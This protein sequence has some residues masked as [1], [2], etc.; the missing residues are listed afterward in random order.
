[1]QT[2]SGSPAVDAATLERW[3]HAHLWH[4]FTQ[5]D[6]WEADGAPLVVEA[7]QGV[8]LI[9]VHGR[10]YLDG[11]SSLWTNV[12]GHRQPRIDA[13][14]V[15]QLGR[16]AH[17]TLLGLSSRPAVELAHRLAR[18]TERQLPGTGLGRVFYSDSGSTAVE[19][20][21]KMAFQW[22]QQ[23]QQ[24][25]RRRTRFAA[26]SEAYHGDTIGSVSVGGID[27]F[28]AVYRPMLF[29]ALRLPAPEHASG[30]E[31]EACLA[32]AEA[33]LEEHGDTLAAL[34]V[35][36]LVQGAA[37]MRMH[38]PAFIG[39][40]LTLAR[41]RGA[42]AIVDE[43][44]TGFGRTGTMFALEQA[45]VTP[46]FL[47]LSKG[48]TA[49]YLPMAATLTTE[50][51]FQAFYAD[52]AE[53]RTFQHGHTFSGNPLAAAAGLASLEVFAEEQTL[54]RL[55]DT[56]PY[57]H[58][59]LTRFLDLPWVGDLRR[60]GMICALEL[61]K[62]KATREPFSVADRVGWRIYLAGLGQG[63]ILR[64]LGNVVYLW[65]PLS[66]TRADI[67]EITD[68]AWTVLADPALFPGMQRSDVHD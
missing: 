35:E 51:V 48:L 1:M 28:H 61:V 42:L 12:H 26:L 66:A 30:T 50:A 9:D 62:N 52:Y 5:Q 20:A 18:L 29:D 57:L 54:A 4:P 32:R 14:I 24:G 60:L 43:V 8:E 65:L 59:R 64:P 55:T 47:C 15:D 17:S 6:E 37:G 2:P 36:P 40:L 31:E 58:A 49:G 33:L 46:D 39:R 10:R 44:A 53:N 3:D 68:R 27:L 41:E 7:A 34:V 21:L 25:H 11:V 16:V 56:V 22:Q 13:A 45:K 63:L 38:S 67:D 19:V 23:Q